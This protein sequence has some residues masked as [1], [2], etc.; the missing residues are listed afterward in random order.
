MIKRKN[1]F[2][3]IEC[4]CFAPDSPRTLSNGNK[5]IMKN[6][7]ACRDV[8]L[9]YDR[10]LFAASFL[11]HIKLQNHHMH[12][13]LSRKLSLF[14]CQNPHING[15]IADFLLFVFLKAFGIVRRRC[16][17]GWLKREANAFDNGYEN[18][19]RRQLT[20]YVCAKP[21]SS[22]IKLEYDG[23]GLWHTF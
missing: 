2:E 23:L 5:F 1:I 14:V 20:I 13:W 8:E 11:C 16:D 10:Q 19:A 7:E 17:E 6:S 22:G 9:F 21:S 3:L 12:T 15:I 18:H 4:R